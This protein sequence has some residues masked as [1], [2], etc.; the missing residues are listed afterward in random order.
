[1]SRSAAKCLPKD[2]SVG[3]H[4]ALITALERIFELEIFEKF[5]CGEQTVQD[6][7]LLLS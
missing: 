2:D 6:G 1:M 4:P 3:T 5:F 7:G